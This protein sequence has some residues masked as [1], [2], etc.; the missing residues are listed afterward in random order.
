MYYMR[1]NIMSCCDIKVIKL[2]NNKYSVNQFNLV[3]LTFLI[4]ASHS[5]TG[6]I[7]FNN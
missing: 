5:C 4:L 6:F 3:S 7:L 2:Y 1:K